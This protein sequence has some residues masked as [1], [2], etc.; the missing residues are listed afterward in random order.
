MLNLWEKI[1]K[2]L[3]IWVTNEDKEINNNR[4]RDENQ[5]RHGNSN[6]NKQFI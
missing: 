5:P 1:E 3:S 4:A 2:A 6:N